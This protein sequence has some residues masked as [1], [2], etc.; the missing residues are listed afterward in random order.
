[1]ADA[2]VPVEGDAPVAVP[3]VGGGMSRRRFLAMA[4]GAAGAVA[5]T[6][7]IRPS[8]LLGDPA[9]AAPATG[10]TLVQVFLRG[11]ADGL[12]IV[13]PLGDSTYQTLRPVVAIPDS[14]ALALDGHFGLHPA[15]L[16]L[17]ALYDQGRLAVVPAA[18]SPNPTR[19]HFESQDLIEKGTPNTALT[20]DGWFGRWM[21][22]TSPW[23]RAPHQCMP[24]QLPTGTRS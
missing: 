17:K 24:L 2:P 15:A 21:N 3:L 5:A 22:Q 6:A 11:G 12:S 23:S 16:K 13:S 1:M 14:S 7:Y 10:N 9:A 20:S 4:G 18:G 8:F 19:S